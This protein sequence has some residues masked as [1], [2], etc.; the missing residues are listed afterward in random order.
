METP[1]LR[2][3]G[4]PED[5]NELYIKREDLLPFSMGGNK[6]R[7]GEAFFDDMKQKGCDCMVIYG[8]RHSNLCRVLSA[9]CKSR[10]V[11]CVM[12]CSHEDGE[13]QEITNNTLLV[14]WTGTE[15]V[16][17]RKQEIAAAVEEV[18][19][20]QKA[21]GR[22]PY[23][24]F[25]NKYG[26]GNEGTAAGA[27]AEAYKEIREYERRRG[28]SFDY[29][30]LPSGTGATQSG[31]ICGKLLMGGEASI[32][33]VMISSREYGRAREVVREGIA[34]YF[35]KTGKSLPEDYQKEIH[36]L[37]QY[38]QGGYGRYDV[39]IEACV[40]EV[41]CRDGV[42]LDPVYT[43]KAFWGMKE[44]LKEKQVEG[45]KVLFLHTGGGPLFYYYLT[46]REKASLS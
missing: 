36:L 32:M 9:L 44:Y 33:G 26:T 19:N 45:K 16:H 3:A 1:I 38:R 46:K 41:Y 4:E 18:M 27:Y 34:S 2:M 15:I 30:F 40:R 7:I 28:F 8:S 14:D 43:A 37:D 42:A 12:I 5:S 17:C 24:I 6:V 20:R 22:T 10:G 29:I 31:L 25:G 39:R 11:P 21:R 23:Y 35:E 13:E